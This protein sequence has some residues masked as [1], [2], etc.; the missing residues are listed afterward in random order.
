MGSDMVKDLIKQLVP[1]AVYIYLTEKQMIGTKR[2]L[3]CE[4]TSGEVICHFD[5]DDWSAQAESGTR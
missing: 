3:A 1:D 2:N 4:A 5:D